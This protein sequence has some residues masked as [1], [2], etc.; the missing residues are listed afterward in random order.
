MKLLALVNDRTYHHR[1]RNDFQ[2][3]GGEGKIFEVKMVRK[4]RPSR[5][6]NAGGCLRGGDVPL[7]SRSFFGNV[8]LNEAIWCTIFIILNI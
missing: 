5:L 4:G 3:G 8:V 1:R 2:S 7:R 6:R